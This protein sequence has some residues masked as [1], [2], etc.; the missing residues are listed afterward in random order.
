ME[1]KV[2]KQTMIIMITCQIERSNTVGQLDVCDVVV[3]DL[4]WTRFGEDQLAKKMKSDIHAKRTA[5][6]QKGR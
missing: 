3:H 5:L 6:I 4:L 1:R 2:D